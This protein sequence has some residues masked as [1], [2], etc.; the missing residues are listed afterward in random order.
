MICD[1]PFGFSSEPSDFNS[2]M[3][4]DRRLD[5]YSK[6]NSSSPIQSKEAEGGVAASLFEC[7]PYRSST[8][9]DHDSIF[10]LCSSEDQEISSSDKHM[11]EEHFLY[12]PRS[13]DQKTHCS[14]TILN[15]F[16]H[17]D[18]KSLEAEKHLAYKPKI[19]LKFRDQNGDRPPLP[20]FSKLDV[21][22]SLDISLTK[23]V[24]Y[25][26]T[27]ESKKMHSSRWCFCAA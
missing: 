13:V 8:D 22:Y 14:D 1:S 23:Q 7:E 16:D 24:E 25:V 9:T 15:P 2:V 10:S 18:F 21:K 17:Q 6:L 4:Q 27:L 3:K 19:A 11:K 5:H 26:F 20:Y 12:S